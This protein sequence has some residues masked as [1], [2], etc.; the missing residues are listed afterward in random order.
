M[1]SFPGS[2][3]VLKGGIALLDPTTG[4]VTRI[5]VLQYNPDTV[6]R[7][8]AVQA[9]ADPPDRTQPL[10]LKAPPVETIKV[11][12]EIDATDQLETPEQ[13]ADTVQHGIH[14]QLAALEA[15]VSPTSTA[16]NA[17]EALTHAGSLEI[18]PMQAPLAV[19]VWSADRIV[20]VRVTDLSITEE[21]FDPTLNPLR[22]KVSLGMRVLTVN[23]VG[24]E[25]RAGTLFMAHLRK[26]E[27]LAGR[28]PT[29]TFGALG[30]TGITA[31]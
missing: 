15:L 2:P 27:S 28:A 19:F 3:R 22:A 9:M 14:P 26:K 8:L 17:S 25:H 31:T 11:D 4:A 20:P 13:F 7:T 5:I 16:L 23:D 18:V 1:S 21:A 10:R 12:A 29:G 30:I 6:T 24:F